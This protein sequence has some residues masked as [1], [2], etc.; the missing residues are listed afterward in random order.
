MSAAPEI[1]PAAAP[2]APSGPKR[3]VCREC[4]CTPERACTGGCDRDAQIRRT[5]LQRCALCRNGVGHS[6][7][8]YRLTIEEFVLDP[9]GIQRAAGLEAFFGGGRAGATLAHVM[10]D[11]PA[12]AIRMFVPLQVLLCQ[13]CAVTHATVPRI[14]ERRDRSKAS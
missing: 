1:P 6:P 5:D 8:F 13:D 9:Q 2:P 10:G 3:G 12:L 11:D 4:G 14:L 7:L